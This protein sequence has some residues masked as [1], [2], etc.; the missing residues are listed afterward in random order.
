[1]DEKNKPENFPEEEQPS[2]LSDMLGA[3]GFK[4]KAQRPGKQE[5]IR[6]KPERESVPDG[7]SPLEQEVKASGWG[8]RAQPELPLEYTDLESEEISLY[9]E[10][11]VPK[12]KR[13]WLF[14][15]I[16]I[17][18]V[19]AM[20]VW[21]LL[22]REPEPPS[23]DVVASYNGK[24][25]TV[26]EL[27]AFI[28]VENAK[29]REHIICPTHGYD[30]TKCTPDEEC[31]AHPVHTLEGYREMVSRLATEQM[32][33]SWAESS[34][35]TQRSDVRHGMSDLLNDAMVTQYIS[36]LHEENVSP[37]SISSWEVQKYY[38]NNQSAYAGK[39]L[40]EVE[41]EIRR[42]LAAQ[43]DEDFF[44]EYLDELK[45]TA[46]LQ[47]NFD[48]LKVT[49]PTQA[50][51]AAYYQ[52]NQ[53][54]YETA[55]TA[56]F[57][58][59]KF[60]GDN[61]DT[62]ATAASRK[63]RSGEAFDSVAASNGGASD[64]SIEKGTG[65][66]VKENT[67]WQMK[68]GQ[69]SDPIDNGDGSWSILELTGLSNSGVRPLSEVQEEITWKLLSEKT[70]TEYE[71]R[72]TETLFSIH[73]RRYTLGDFYT[74]FQ[75]LS[76]AYQRQFSSFEMKQQLLEQIIAQELLLEKSGDGSSTGEDHSMEEL[77]IRYLA[78]ILHQDEVDN[79]MEEPTEEEIRQFYEENQKDMVVPAS[80]QLNLIWIDQGTNGEKKEDALAK[81]RSAQDALN[82]GMD[83][84]TA[85]RQYSEDSS[86]ASNGG[87]ISGSF[88]VEDL[89]KPLAQAIEPLAVGGISPI[90][91]YNG[92]YYIVQVRER[93]EERQQSFEEVADTI[94]AH[95][96]AQQHEQLEADMQKTLLERV[97]LVIFDKTLRRLVKE[98]EQGAAS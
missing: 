18:A 73:S 8:Q 97:D 96:Q 22:T 39:T 23:P 3:L 75:E 55:P 27:N 29:E 72:K 16:G 49:Q 28:A 19:I 2:A 86:A 20:G 34:G 57:R 42:T 21:F 15:V 6:N 51:I 61:A 74:E 87:Q 33:V 64:G 37:E 80:L 40:P 67:L 62:Q 95:L 13:R 60:S 47:V 92:G 94:K 11:P 90:V 76:P 7:E 4:P 63:L 71:T 1:M 56:K 98:M 12:K 26:E 78:Q 85:A 84:A 89:A 14:P 9:E 54:D 50:E 5:D 93:T 53:S 81:A 46:G 69:V 68:A 25:I 52:T 59:I 36:Q 82:G 43:K 66:K 65:P 41:N 17:A 91:E 48:L 77:R 70:A 44:T 83:F 45:K 31:E 58:E 88:H 10:L 24:N 38:D 32:I 30:H 79:Q 35:I